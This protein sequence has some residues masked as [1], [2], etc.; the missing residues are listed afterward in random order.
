MNR[1]NRVENVKKLL[2]NADYI[3]TLKGRTPEEQ[4]V[5]DKFRAYN[6]ELNRR[7]EFLTYDEKQ[8]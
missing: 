8:A 5:L 7:H 6:D 3:L 4:A 1:S 2:Q